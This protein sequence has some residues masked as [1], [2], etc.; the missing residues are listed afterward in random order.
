MAA[1]LPVVKSH[2][3]SKGWLGQVSLEQSLPAYRSGCGYYTRLLYTMQVDL[4]SFFYLFRNQFDHRRRAFQK[5]E[6]P[7]GAKAEDC[8]QW[9]QEYPDRMAKS[10]LPNSYLNA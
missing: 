5:G 3:R 1:R 9:Q 6:C 10:T 4:R 2:S 8:L 7:N